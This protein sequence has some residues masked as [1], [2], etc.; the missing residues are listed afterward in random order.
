LHDLQM[1]PTTVLPSAVETLL[2]RATLMA[3]LERQTNQK[4]DNSLWR[5]A[6]WVEKSGLDIETPPRRLGRN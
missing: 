4:F 2:G 5:L 1:R 6:A 3:R